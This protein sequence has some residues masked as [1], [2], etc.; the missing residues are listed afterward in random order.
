MV[1]TRKGPQDVGVYLYDVQE[2]MVNLVQSLG[3]KAQV[4]QQGKP[5]KL[6]GVNHLEAFQHGHKNN[7]KG[8]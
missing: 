8:V 5:W 4:L 3:F 7:K 1:M 6:A 2:V